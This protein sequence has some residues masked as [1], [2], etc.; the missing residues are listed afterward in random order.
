VPKKN[1]N[2][3]FTKGRE[4]EAKAIDTVQALLGGLPRDHELLIEHLHLIQDSVGHIPLNL[5]AALAEEMHLSQADV[6]E[7]ASFYAHFTLI[8]DAAET[9]PTL[10]VRVCDGPACKMDGADGLLAAL[11]KSLG[12]HI[13]VTSTPCMGACDRAPAA[14]VAFNRVAPASIDAIE[15]AVD[16][17]LTAPTLPDTLDMDAYMKDGGYDLL[18]ACR[19]GERSVDDVLKEIDLSGLRGLGGAGFPVADKWRF[20]LDQP[21]PRVLVVNADEGE[22]GTFKDRHCLETDPH[23]VLE[24]A[25]IAA[26]AIEADSIY[27]YL[28]DEYPHIR[29]LLARELMRLDSIGLLHETAIHLRRG[30]GSYVCGEETALLE[31]LE[32]KRGLPRNRPPYPAQSGLFGR[33][34][35]INN[36]ETLYWLR[37]IFRDGGEAY[38][39]AGCQHF[40]SVSGRVREPGIKQAPRGISAQQLIDEYSGGMAEGHSLKGFLPGGAAGSILPASLAD[41]PLDFGS[42][43]EHGGF[44]GSSAVIVLSDQDNVAEMARDLTGFFEDESCGQCTPCRIGCEK[45]GHLLEEAT[46]NE[47]LIQEL[48]VTM[49]EAS[50]CGLGQSA[51][52]PALSVLKY[53]RDDV[54]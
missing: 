37:D 28:R 45:L 49:A 33:P 26:W 11:Q 13:R 6:Y 54:S 35:L 50:I 39:N 20:L 42:L 5:L 43:E 44:I 53:F 22:P 29:Q 27:I 9:S 3:Y 34:T 18:Q 36:V 2:N 24:A 31:S 48:A 15:D 46:D 14:A 30:A 1:K 10:T 21:K 16:K 12:E 41:V 25:L 17:G 19:A 40:Y 7:V 51:A 47:T 4:V 52:N 23:R 8:D 32:G 38:R